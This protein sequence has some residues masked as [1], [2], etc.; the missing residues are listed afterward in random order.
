MTAG[1]FFEIMAYIGVGCGKELAPKSLEVYFDLLGDL[2]R[3]TLALA[4]KRVV[5]EHPWATFPSIAELRAAAVETI[6]GEVS[7]LCPAEAWRI[8]WAVA[9]STDPEIDGSF[10]RA[11]KRHDAP[12]AVV[13]A[14]RTF[15]LPSLC[16]GDEPVGVVRGQFLKVFEQLAARDK[17]LALLPPR[18]AESIE[19]KGKPIAAP[20]LQALAGIGKPVEKESA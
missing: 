9:G 5:L 14:I 16:Y 3:E 20:V 2:P 18:L 7:E 10:S 17:R 8:A 13:E 11:C 6:R 1:E 19:S 12:P 15:G 4:A